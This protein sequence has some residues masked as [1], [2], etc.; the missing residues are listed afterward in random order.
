MRHS[1]GGWGTL[2]LNTLGDNNHSGLWAESGETSDSDIGGNSGHVAEGGNSGGS[3]GGDGG[4]G[5]ELH[6]SE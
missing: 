1:D 4:E 5:G 3:E 2:L 6:F